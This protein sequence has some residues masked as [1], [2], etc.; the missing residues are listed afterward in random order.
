ML[1][2]FNTRP[3]LVN[4]EAVYR[5]NSGSNIGSSIGSKEKIQVVL[6]THLVIPSSCDSLSRISNRSNNRSGAH[7]TKNVESATNF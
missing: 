6:R 1:L 5:V 3:C 4:A 7:L 2:M